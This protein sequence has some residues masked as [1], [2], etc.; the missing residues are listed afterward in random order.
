[1]VWF[2][3]AVTC[4]SR[5]ELGLPQTPDESFMLTEDDTIGSVLGAFDEACAA[6]RRATAQLGLDDVLRGNRRG[7]LLLRWVTCTSCVS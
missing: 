4:R 7:P 3:E 5:V 2:E 1:M 6:S